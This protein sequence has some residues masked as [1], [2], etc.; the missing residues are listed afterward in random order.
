[1][2]FMSCVNYVFLYILLLLYHINRMNFVFSG[3]QMWE[4]YNM[5]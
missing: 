1:M 4:L 3:R 2:S 5:L